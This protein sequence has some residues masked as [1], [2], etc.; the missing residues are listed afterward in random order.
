MGFAW[1]PPPAF[2]GASLT[3]PICVCAPQ[4][5]RAGLRPYPVWPRVLA[6]TLSCSV[7]PQNHEATTRGP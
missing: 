7:G 2:L 3:T 4:A 5:S 6:R 1:L